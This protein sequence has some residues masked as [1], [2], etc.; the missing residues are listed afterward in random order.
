MF[1]LVVFIR[2]KLIPHYIKE[3]PDTSSFKMRQGL[4]HHGAEEV[5][6]GV[7]SYQ[8]EQLKYGIG[9]AGRGAAFV[10]CPPFAG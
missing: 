3:V 8:N 1:R 5:L 6:S 9:L 4:T 2:V 10:Q 7:L